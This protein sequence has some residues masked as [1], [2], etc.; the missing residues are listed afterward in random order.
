MRKLGLIGGMSWVSTRTYYEWINRLVQRRT[1]PLASAPL[2]IESLD[3]RRLHGL[4]EPADWARA[5]Q[6]LGES[7]RQLESAGA[8]AIVIAA[9]SMHKVYDEVAAQVDVPILHIAECIGQRMKADGVTNAALIGTRNVMTE[10]FY[11]QRLVAH[12]VDLLPPDMVNVEK[13]DRIIYQEL[14]LGKATRDAQRALKTMITRKEQDG[15]QAIV[16]ACTELEMVVD[17]DANV[18]PIFD[19]ARIHCEAAVDWLLEEG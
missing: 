14:M 9:N 10:N 17:V 2:L 3:F 18:L 15:T 5:A 11:R 1:E 16:L 12:G 4:H 19:S 8:G 7:A 6:V 13:L